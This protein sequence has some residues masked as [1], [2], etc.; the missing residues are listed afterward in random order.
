MFSGIGMETAFLTQMHV[1]PS[2]LR[3]ITLSLH[4]TPIRKLEFSAL[5]SRSIQHLEGVV[6]NDFQVL[7]INA[8]FRF[9]RLQ[10][11]A[12]YFSTTQIYSSYFAAYPETQRGRFYIRI[13]R[14]FGI[15]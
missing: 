6:A 2:D 1:V 9:R 10:F 11:V 14:P 7:D 5:F 8:T 13:S 3:G 12:G 15:R 4:A